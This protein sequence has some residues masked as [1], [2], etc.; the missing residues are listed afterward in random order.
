MHHAATEGLL[1]ARRGDAEG[2]ERRFLE[3]LRI[4]ADTEFLVTHGDLWLARS[5]AQDG[6]GDTAGAVAA[7]RQ[8]LACFERKE[9]LPPIQTAQAR[10][11]ELGG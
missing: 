4:A 1:L 6:L 7:A 11:A 9:Q 8:A 5:E 2:S 10:L 3:S